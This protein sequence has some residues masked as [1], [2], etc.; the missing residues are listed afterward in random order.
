MEVA[1]AE[2]EERLASAQSTWQ[3]E[4]AGLRERIVQL[5][6][7]AEAAAVD[8]MGGA[9]ALRQRADVAAAALAEVG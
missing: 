1:S 5:E 7:A 2:V 6:A 4:E 3:D 8:A 9:A